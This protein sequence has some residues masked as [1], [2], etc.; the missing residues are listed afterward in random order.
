MSH[1]IYLLEQFPDKEWNYNGLSANPN[2]DLKYI[3]NNP[4]K[5]WNWSWLS[6]NPNITIQDILNNPDK[7]WDWDW[8]SR[9]PNITIQ[10][11]LNNPDKPW[12]W[13]ELSR[14][15]FNYKKIE[16]NIIYDK[17]HNWLYKPITGITGG[18]IGIIPRV[19][20]KKC[21]L[22]LILYEEEI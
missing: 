10:D 8:S 20:M 17:L 5:P 13:V 11:V 9:N 22:G 2:I 4:D 6:S 21:N 3:L 14:N 15:K 12:D 19:G 18:V 7:P 1:L 16:K